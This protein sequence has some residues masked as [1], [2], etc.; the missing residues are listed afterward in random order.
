MEPT[1]TDLFSFV[2]EAQ[3]KPLSPIVRRVVSTAAE[4][5]E[6]APDRVDFLHT[7]LC[8]VGMPRKRQESRVFERR[9]GTASMLLEAGRPLDKAG[10][11]GAAF[12]LWHTSTPCHGA[13]QRRGS[14]KTNAPDRSWRQHAGFS[15]DSWH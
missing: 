2:P 8:Q 13:C 9:S 14:A 4:I 11:E 10:M 3:I 15:A 7:V 6:D 12:A 1:Q 5:M